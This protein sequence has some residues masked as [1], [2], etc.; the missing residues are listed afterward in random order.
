MGRAQVNY[1]GDFFGQP[2]FLTVS[3][4]LNAEHYATAFGSVYTFGP[5]FRAEASNTT[6]HLAEFWMIEPEIAFADLK[7]DMN[8]AEV[9]IPPHPPVAPVLPSC[10]PCRVGLSHR[11][12]PPLRASWRLP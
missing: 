2:S 11:T 9:P 8:C 3:G 4:Q 5:T 6:R 12:T 1:A 7:D 10:P